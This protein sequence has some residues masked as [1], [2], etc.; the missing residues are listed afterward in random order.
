MKILVS[1]THCI[2]DFSL[3]RTGDFQATTSPF[4]FQPDS[5]FWIKIDIQCLG[6]TL[7]IWCCVT[8]YLTQSDP[9]QQDSFSCCLWGSGIRHILAGFSGLGLSLTGCHVGHG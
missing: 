8:D 4:T 2:L 6:S 1:I 9:K 5:V 3:H 7:V